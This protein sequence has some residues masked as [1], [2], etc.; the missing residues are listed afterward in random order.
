LE[1][2]VN[3]NREVGWI[4]NSYVQG[5]TYKLMDSQKITL[6]QWIIDL[7][8]LAEIINDLGSMIKSE[9]GLALQPYEDRH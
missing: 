5:N 1:T 6:R 4:P 7:K 2:P 8:Y 9:L 3:R